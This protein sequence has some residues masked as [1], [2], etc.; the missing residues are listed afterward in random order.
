M[1]DSMDWPS[2]DYCGCSRLAYLN[3]IRRLLCRE[4]VEFLQ[5]AGYRHIWTFK[6]KH[7]FVLW[8]YVFDLHRDLRRSFLTRKQLTLRSADTEMEQIVSEELLCY[9]HLIRLGFAPVG[10]LLNVDVISAVCRSLAKL[11]NQLC[12]AP[13]VAGAAV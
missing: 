12:P 1:N 2:E 8:Q 11:E 10:Y 5:T 7:A 6:W 13:L 9:F 4:D 3:V